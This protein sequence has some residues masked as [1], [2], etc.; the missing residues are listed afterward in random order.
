M[1]EAIITLL[2]EGV[3][4]IFPSGYSF[5][6]DNETNYIELGFHDFDDTFNKDGLE[7]LSVEGVE[8]SLMWKKEWED[9]Q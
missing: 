6:P 5:T 3:T 8:R 1:T 4:L 7:P 9:E 2:R